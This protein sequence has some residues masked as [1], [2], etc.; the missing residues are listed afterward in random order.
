MEIHTSSRTRGEQLRT[1]Y[2]WLRTNG[3]EFSKIEIRDSKSG[4]GIYALEQIG[5]DGR[6]ASI[7][8]KLVITGKV[9]HDTIGTNEQQQLEQKDDIKQSRLMLC[10]F[11]IHERFVMKE[12]SFWK[13]YIDILPRKFHTPLQFNDE[14]LKFL[15][16]TPA[17][18]S[19]AE[20][21]EGYREYLQKALDLVPESVIPRDVLIYDNYLWAM[22][23][24]SSRSFSKELMEGTLCRLTAESEVLLPLLDMANHY[25]RTPVT[26]IIDDDGIGFSIDAVIEPGEQIFNNYG[27]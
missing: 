22:S 26:W 19:V 5:L 18:F 2:E 20:R 10:L 14:E 17:E 11:L 25:P 8:N 21:H 7:P 4:G 12:D 6:Y 1:F 15:R 27:P 9:C 23:V 13:P 16:G 3:A 24:L